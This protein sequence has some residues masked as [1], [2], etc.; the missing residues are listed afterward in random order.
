M[1]KDKV[2]SVYIF[3]DPPILRGIQRGNISVLETGAGE[4]V[5]FSATTRY[6]IPSGGHGGTGFPARLDR[7][8]RGVTRG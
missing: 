1:G 7:F 4:G 3:T 8:H 5:L 6:P 2:S